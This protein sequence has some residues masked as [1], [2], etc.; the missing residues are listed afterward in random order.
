MV[1][2]LGA[3]PAPQQVCP[4]LPLR[5]CVASGRYSHFSGLCSQEAVLV[6]EAME[7]LKLHDRLGIGARGTKPWGLALNQC[8]LIT[9]SV[10]KTWSASPPM[11]DL[12]QGLSLP[13]RVP[14]CF[15]APHCLVTFSTMPLPLSS[16][17][18]GHIHAQFIF[19]P[20]F[21]TS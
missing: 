7:S 17:L 9:W 13:P 4:A 1:S 16:I 3:T 15:P 12:F 8:L 19:P 10:V 21:P 2:F 5:L 18:E 11:I 20:A 14:R 6:K